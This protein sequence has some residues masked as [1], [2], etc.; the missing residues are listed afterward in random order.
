MQKFL[1][2]KNV[3]AIALICVGLSMELGR[4]VPN[5]VVPKPDVAILNIDKPNDK[6]LALVQPVSD[7]V[8]DPT[9]RAKLAIYSQEFAVR[10][11]KYDAQLQQINDVLSL[12]AKEF[13]KDDI[14]DKYSG[15]DD[16]IITM[17]TTAVNS[18]ENHKLTE[19][20]KNELSN[21]FMGFAWAL[22][23]KK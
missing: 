1:N 9:D 6:V 10:V 23:Q 17:I 7:L 2:F 19:P 11:K 15:L 18:D 22:I 13:F 5:I 16:G 14:N 20:E 4:F 8:T 3:L 12:S 21:V